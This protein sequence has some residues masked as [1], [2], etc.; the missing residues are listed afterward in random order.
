MKVIAAQTDNH[1]PH[2]WSYAPSYEILPGVL[3]GRPDQLLT[4]AYWALR[5]ETSREEGRDFVNRDGS[6]EEEVGF[7][8]L[9]GYGVTAEVATAFFE[10]LKDVGIF[11]PSA[12][13]EEAKILDI[14]AEPL[15]VNGREQ[16][17]RFP[18]QRSAR[19]FK[20]MRS[21]ATMPLDTQ[22]ALTF[23][24]NLQAIEG[25]G[26]KTASWITRHWLGSND[27]AILDIHILRAGW[28]INLFRKEVRL[29]RDYATLERRFLRLAN[30]INVP[31]SILDAVMWSDMRKFG[32]RLLRMRDLN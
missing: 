23:R 17:Y 12:G 18:K 21:L 13:V 24:D 15:S 22:D 9:G 19:L 31:A 30:V 16:R 4:P 28:A 3:F 14:L 11:E 20:A 1:F 7:C 26:P 29:P 8:L 2:P 6:L 25:V 5:C 32:S 10:R 27:V